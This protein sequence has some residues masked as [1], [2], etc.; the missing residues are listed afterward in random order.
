MTGKPTR[1]SILTAE[2]AALSDVEQ[3]VMSSDPLNS[4]IKRSSPSA[5]SSDKNDDNRRL[6]TIYEKYLETTVD[7]CNTEI[8]STEEHRAADT[9]LLLMRAE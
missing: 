8:A 9:V 7:S 2:V 4:E 1:R 5:M 6:R 3:T